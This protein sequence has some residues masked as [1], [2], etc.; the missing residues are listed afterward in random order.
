MDACRD[1]LPQHF[2]VALIR[3]VFQHLRIADAILLLQNLRVAQP[4]FFIVSSW[5]QG[6]NRDLQGG[7]SAFEA[8]SPGH[9][10]FQGYD[11]RKPPFNFPEPLKIW[12]EMAGEELLLYP[13][14]VL[15]SIDSI[16]SDSKQWWSE[17]IVGKRT[18]IQACHTDASMSLK[19]F[20]SRI[21]RPILT[22][23][24]PFALPTGY[25]E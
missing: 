7:S 14:A 11:L 2:T 12:K 24:A 13:I 16:V 17:K 10:N 18:R 20:L 9:E 22:C 4:Q 23:F 5:P 6:T 15:E 21:W 1:P 19:K 25:S 8:V 3:H